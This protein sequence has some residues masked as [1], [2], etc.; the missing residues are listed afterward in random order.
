M[1]HKSILQLAA[2]LSLAILLFVFSATQAQA[3]TF[4]VNTTG[5]FSDAN[6]GNGICNTSAGNCTLRAA[7]EESNAF[8]GTDTISFGIAGAGVKTIAPATAYPIITGILTIDGWTQGGAGYNGVPLIELSGT[9]GIGIGFQIAAGSSTV[10]GL[11]INRF[12]IGIY[13][14]TLPGNTV[15]ACYIG[16]DATGTIDLGN[17]T[18]V[19]AL[20]NDNIIGGT[21]APRRNVISGNTTGIYIDSSLNT[22]VRGNYIGTNAA[23]DADLSN[24]DGVLIRDA[25]VA[26]IGGGSVGERNVISGNTSGITIDDSS[27]ITISGNYIGTNAAGNAGLG[28]RLKG[29]EIS[30]SSNITIGGTIAS[31]RNIISGNGEGIAIGELGDGIII[32]ESTEITISGNYIGTDAGGTL[33]LGN[34]DRGVEINDGST[35]ITIGGTTVGERNVISEN[36]YGIEI[37]GSMTTGV[38]VKG[39]YIG[40]DATGSIDLGNSQHGV[41]I[42]DSPSN[43][44]GGA[45]AGERNIISGNDF[46]G[47]FLTVGD[48]AENLII[49]NYIGTDADGL[50]DLGNGYGVYIQTGASDN[51]IGG[52][53]AGEANIIAFSDNSGIAIVGDLIIPAPGNSI[54][55]NSIFSNQGLGID[56]APELYNLGDVTANDA[57]DADTGANNLQNYPVLTEA[58]NQGGNTDVSVSFNS[59]PG[60]SFAIEFYAN[61]SCDSSSHGEGETFLAQTNRTTNAGGNV[62]FVF[63]PATQLALGTYITATATRSIAPFDTSEFSECIQVTNPFPPTVINANDSG[64]GSLRQ[65]ILDTN[66]LNGLDV[67]RFNIPGAGVH[68]IN[69]LSPLP[70]ITDA[71]IIDGRTQPGFAGLPL[72]E[73][74]GTSAGAGADGIKI[75]SGGTTVRG[76]IINRFDGDGIELMTGFSNTITGNYIGTDATGTIDLGNEGNGIFAN[77]SE[78]NHIGGGTPTTR[79]L[80]SGNN[81]N[82]VYILNS[83]E[84]GNEVIGNIIGTDLTRTVALG[85][86][87]SGVYVSASAHNIIG[88]A[89]AGAGNLISANGANG[90]RFNDAFDNQAGG[91][92]IGTDGSGTANLGNT[93]NGV[94]F[95]GESNDNRIGGNTIAFN[96]DGI[97]VNNLST[98]N[99][100]RGNAIFSNLNL[101]ID[102]AP[103]GKTPNDEDDAD[104]GANNLQNFPV[105]TNVFNQT[106]ATT[107]QGTLNSTADTEFTIEFFASPSCDASGNGEGQIF[108]GSTMVTTDAN[109]DMTFSFSPAAQAPLGGFITTTATNRD[110]SDTSEFSQ[111]AAIVSGPGNL[112]FSAATYDVGEGMG[113]KTITVNRTDGTNGTITVDYATSDAEATAGQDYTATSGTLVFLNGETSKTFDVPIIND[114]IDEHTSEGILLTLS[115]PSPNVNLTPRAEAVLSIIDNDNAPQISI[116]N[117]SAEET[118]VG[119][120]QFVFTVQLT[121]QSTL[122]I[123]VDVATANGSATLNSDYL[124]TSGQLTFAPLETAKTV[125]V[126]VLGDLVVELNETF[127]VNLTNPT[128]TTIADNQGLGTIVD[129]DNAGKFSFAFTPYSGVENTQVLVTVAR[130]NGDAGTVS[131]DYETSGGNASPFADYTP[132][133]GTLVFGDTET[134]KTFMVNLLDDALVEPTE[135]FNVVLSNPIGGATLGSPSVAAVNILDNDSGTLFT[136]SGRILKT[137]NTP[138]VG[139]TVNMTGTQTATTTTDSLGQYAFTNVVPN[140]QHGG[141][142]SAIGYTFTPTS[143]QYSNLTADVTNADFTAT[144]AP[145]RQLRIIGGN[146]APTQDITAIVELVAQGDENSVGFSMNFNQTILMNPTVVLNPDAA[147]ATLIVNNTQTA[148]GKLGIILALPAGQSFTAGTKS[149]VTVTF[150]TTATNLYSS[151]VTFGDIPTLRETANI[152]ADP[153]PTNYLDGA[154]TFAQGWEADLAPRFTGSNTGSITVADFTQVGRFAAGLDTNYQLNEFQR[155][156]CAPRVSLGNGLVTVSDYTQAGRYAANIDPATPA[157]GAAAR[158]MRDEGRGMNMKNSSLNS[159]LIPHPSSLLPT[160]IRVVNVQSSPNMQVFVSIETDA[161]GGENGFGFT[162]NYD[163]LKLSNPLVALG[164]GVPVGTALI[165]NTTQTGKVGVI[166]GLPFGVGLTAGTKQL[167]TIRFDVAA[168]ASGGLSALTFGDMPVVREV[169]DVN[170]NVL[171]SGF[172]DGAID[173][174]APTAATVSVGGRVLSADNRAV[175]GAQIS[176]TDQTGNVRLART[177]P[178]GYY[179]FEEIPAGATYIFSVSHKLYQFAPQVLTI[180]EATDGL[181]FT[182]LP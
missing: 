134:S 71:V 171:M 174:L 22:I 70:T 176:M 16:T 111:C 143:W 107:I 150:N 146:A 116:D 164:S 79:N 104:T 112:T 131:V 130:T 118:N 99:A 101:G 122:P 166:L 56:L 12:T 76:L 66:L 73:L 181:N 115:N 137:D 90:I 135:N 142:P 125:S 147:T 40:T 117:V 11:I 4:T 20:S 93:L 81:F 10:R 136:I 23:G 96:T 167:I 45:T 153:L 35:N 94:R 133:S 139:A 155:A 170:A 32:D 75:T 159:S 182:A 51:R 53:A 42:L 18:G 132:T 158:G 168:N 39:N 105:V 148:T 14:T 26:T 163:S 128:N 98:S 151:P 157:G 67:I 36:F 119:S 30:L 140:G 88:N 29:I 108:I 31:E 24:D 103:N 149:L 152:N 127:F 145:S 77:G 109:G 8:A 3:G 47:I 91:N 123:T 86:L 60:T 49:G 85:N 173:I 162:L 126:T 64:A 61:S 2:L 138:L 54:R 7:I 102:L 172:T 62:S 28:N 114:T 160:A 38:Q 84:F 154:V 6:P 92:F 95:E 41:V 21:V 178:F 78:R 80:I 55:R 169:S 106:G 180:N 65:T 9:N 52:T 1:K 100:F 129:D 58:F 110:T 13:L 43:V 48:A 89:T 175:S 50:S 17:S 121:N 27:N 34:S 5:D 82:G 72:I 87:L 120:I 83:V 141:H 74:N 177:N 113:S 63:T 57:G 124:P 15:Q 44:V 161:Q 156:D 97:N 59:T 19:Y 33:D 68:T 165:P 179:S 37:S 144:P 46:S 69:L 25:N